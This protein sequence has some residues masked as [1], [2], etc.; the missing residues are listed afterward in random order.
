VRANAR[1]IAKADLTRCAKITSALR[2][3]TKSTRSRRDRGERPQEPAIAIPKRISGE[4]TMAS[5]PLM[6]GRG[7]FV[8]VNPEADLVQCPAR[9]RG[10]DAVRP[11]GSLFHGAPRGSP[12]RTGCFATSTEFFLPERPYLTFTYGDPPGLSVSSSLASTVEPLYRPTPWVT[13][14]LPTSR[15]ATRNSD[16][17]RPCT[18]PV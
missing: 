13:T 3:L 17:D 14:L 15:S 10:D 18:K 8:C 11:P 2:R 9:P 5:I 12:T 7:V 16:R 6:W 1:E 4:F